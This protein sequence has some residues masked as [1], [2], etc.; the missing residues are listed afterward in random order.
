MALLGPLIT[1]QKPAVSLSEDFRVLCQKDISHCRVTLGCA[2]FGLIGLSAWTLTVHSFLS[3]L[4][5]QL[6][7]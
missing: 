5:F 3:Q 4:A 6:G 7:A 2:L 1:S